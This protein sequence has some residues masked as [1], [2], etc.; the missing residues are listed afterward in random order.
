MR[1]TLDHSGYVTL[2]IEDAGGRRVRNLLADTWFEAGTHTVWWDGYDQGDKFVH[3]PKAP[4]SNKEAVRYTIHRRRV[5]PGSYQIRGLVHDDIKLRYLTPIH[6]PGNPPWHTL[7]SSGAWLA[8]H[9]PP[10]KVLFLPDGSPHG[11][12]PQLL[13]TAAGSAEVGHSGM[14]LAMTGR[15]LYGTKI[16]PGIAPSGVALAHDEGPQREERY[17]AYALLPIKRKGFF[18]YGFVRDVDPTQGHAAMY[19][20]LACVNMPQEPENGWGYLVKHPRMGMAAHNG[21]VLV[22]CPWAGQ[23]HVFKIQ[24]DKAKPQ[25][26]IELPHVRGM[27]FDRRGRLFIASGS[28]LER[29]DRPQP[30]DGELGPSKILASDLEEPHELTL[31]SKGRV[32]VSQAGQSHQ[33]R[34]F[35]ADGQR[36]RTIGKPGGSQFGLYDE[37]RMHNPAGI[38]VD[39]EGKL[40][41]CEADYAPKRISVWDAATGQFLKAFYGPPRYGGGGHLDPQDRTRFYYP[42]K[43]Q[44]IE[45]VVDYENQTSKPRAI[46]WLKG[47][48]SGRAP[49]TVVYR[50]GYRY[51]INPF[52]G[53]SYFLAGRLDVFRYDPAEGKARIIASL[54]D[55][56]KK[57]MGKLD[58]MNEALEDDPQVKARIA[59]AHGS[60]VAWSDLNVDGA[61][62]AKELQTGE[63]GGGLM[64]D[65]DLSVC[66]EAGW[67]MA[68]P[69]ITEEGIPV[70]NLSAA[71]RF[72]ADVPNWLG[73]AL[74]VD[75]DTYV[76]SP[77][78]GGWGGG[79]MTAWRQGRRLWMY[80]THLGSLA[81]AP[82]F[83]GQLILPKRYIGFRFQPMNTQIGPMF[84]VNAY[85]GSIYVFTADGL[86]V[87]DLGGSVLVKPLLR[88]PEAGGGML[89]DDVSFNDEHFWPAIQQMTDGSIY[90]TAGK[91]FTG[92][93][94]IEGLEST[95]PVG[96]F[97]LQASREMLRHR[98]EIW[99]DRPKPKEGEQI[100]T[101]RIV[102]TPPRIDGQLNEWKQADWVPIGNAR[103]IRGA[104]MVHNETLYAAWRTEDPK[105]LDNDTPE[106]W[107]RMF[108]T[109]GGLDLM[110]RT[111]PDAQTQRPGKR[112]GSRFDL[113][114]EGD[115]RLLVSRQ[116]DPIKG[117]VRAV[118]FQQVGERLGKP[119]DYISPV[120]Q[121]RFDAVA[122]ISEE[123]TLGQAAGSY[124]LAVPL[125]VIGLD[126]QSGLETRGDIGVLIGN[127]V[128]TRVRLYWANDAAGVVSDIPS[129]AR[130]APANW[131]RWKFQKAAP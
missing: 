64:F 16:G 118:R 49:G 109:G 24:G 115:I 122:D 13:V 84:A 63:F 110:I 19:Q 59:N 36:L 91:E 107:Q 4:G 85:R 14:W 76:M 112:G 54:G 87:T 52:I 80:H 125:Y 78:W 23:I 9:T 104:V 97:E 71:K 11:N 101:I 21:V 68:P 105:L 73:N 114:S 15:K 92:V 27:S 121:V 70:W 65:R 113:A 86:Y 66:T 37:Q 30:C 50:G 81:M 17:Y 108:A 10:G 88:L 124:E 79:P 119:I 47:H 94:K 123:V 89:I 120:G 41:V 22:G 103:N 20:Q 111:Q 60:F 6:S 1:F 126:V 31:D 57:S 131:G 5:E 29:F 3:P 18:L 128:E 26:I 74:E 53:P 43:N 33:V 96:P 25:A 40:W 130:L 69:R 106:G 2:I 39:A 95:H 90:L 99:L 61:V 12:Q 82:Q 42:S 55:M 62:Q 34:V 56:G 46:Y 45:Y 83:V 102:D 77:G 116:G 93:F 58:I 72:S 38:A 100:L 127:G 7:D 35:S 48:S 67:A 117:R 75:K 44:G 98:P 51:L 129:E 28:Q 32:Y 8:D